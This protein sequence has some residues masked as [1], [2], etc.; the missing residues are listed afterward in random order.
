M[1]GENPGP[2]SSF[3]AT[4][5]KVEKSPQLSTSQTANCQSMV[6]VLKKLPAATLAHPLAGALKAYHTEA[7]TPVSN[8]HHPSC[9]LQVYDGVVP[10]PGDTS[11][12]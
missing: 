3:A 2:E 9:E 12:A 11:P 4:S 8:E 10:A 5:V 6:E 7:C 1:Y